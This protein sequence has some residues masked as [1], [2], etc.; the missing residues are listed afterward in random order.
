MIDLLKQYV[1]SGNVL[2]SYQFDKLPRS[3]KITYIRRCLINNIHF[4]KSTIEY[5]IKNL[6]NNT[7]N[8]ELMKKIVENEPEWLMFIK[9][10]SEDVQLAAVRKS[11]YNII[12]IKNPTENVQ[13][14]VVRRDGEKIKW[15][16]DNGITTSK[17][18]QLAAVS[19]HGSCIRH[20]ENP[21]E[22]IQLAAVK[23]FADSITYIKNPYPSVIKLYKELTFE[24]VL[25]GVVEN[26]GDD[27]RYIIEKGFE[28]SERVQLAA[29]KNDGNAIKYI[30]N[31]SE[32][33]QLSAIK[34]NIKAFEF[35][36]NPYPSVIKLYNELTK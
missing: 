27:I 16:M 35:I 2:N 7:F 10:P 12:Y 29:V 28:P 5:I 19:Y 17:D 32:K 4:S 8:D 15:I 24:N 26:N 22:P 1:D 9:D 31:P 3:L 6:D 11:A 21:S 14:E 30:K 20:I 13:L 33:V 25:L 23:N 36:K 34:N 18:V